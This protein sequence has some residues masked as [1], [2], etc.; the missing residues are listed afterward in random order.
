M[1]RFTTG[2]TFSTGDQVTATLL[3]NS[4]NN[5]A[6]ASD[7]VDD[8]TIEL[9]SNALRI[10][11]SGVS[12]AK[13]ASDAVDKTKIDFIAD[14]LATTDTHVLIA[15]GTDFHNKA[16]SGDITITN[17]GVTTIKNDVALAG[18]PTTTTQSANDNSTKIATT[19]YVTGA[20]SVVSASLQNSWAN[21]GSGYAD[22]AYYKNN[23]DMV[24]IQGVCKDGTT[25]GGTLIF[26]LNSGHRP[27]ARQTF[28]AVDNQSASQPSIDVLANGEV[29]VRSVHNN[30]FLSL[31]GISFKAGL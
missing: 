11:D 19:A 21:H 5:A 30:G 24:F 3:N 2:N 29:Q 7:S 1:A 17:A 23:D 18:N 10:K 8:S 15:D 6:L 13:I 20:T 12:T 28:S 27:A 4:V 25:T 26:T 14:D 22:V 9:N 31:S 16:V